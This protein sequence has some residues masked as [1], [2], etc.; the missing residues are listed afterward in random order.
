MRLH[1]RGYS[2]VELAIVML[3]IGVLSR[4]AIVPIHAGFDQAN[5]A[6]TQ[7]QLRIVKQAVIGYLVTTGTLPCPLVPLISIDAGYEQDTPCLRSVGGLPAARLGIQGAINDHGE[8]LDSW[9]QPLVYAVSLFSH[10]SRGD[11]SLPDWTSQGELA[12]VGVHALDADLVLCLHA[13]AATCSQRELR[14]EKVAWVALS[15]G[16]DISVRGDQLEN[17][18]NDEVFVSRL[19]SVTRGQEFDDL[20]SWS[21]RSEL[22]YWLLQSS[23]FP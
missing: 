5:R 15:L 11:P 13:V 19:S 3:V 1:Q 16:A 23:W 18:D 7:K 14:A 6:A 4:A 9:G 21:S 10:S 12:A 22:V 2:L 17:Q 8:L 20:L